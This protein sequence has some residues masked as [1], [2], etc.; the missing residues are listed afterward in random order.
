MK[1]CLVYG[2]PNHDNEERFVGNLCAPCH[3]MLTTG[4]IAIHN[5]NFI[6][7]MWQDLEDL[8]DALARARSH[9]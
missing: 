3:K 2:C 7:A 9:E 5:G 8:R 1:K 6:S 4:D